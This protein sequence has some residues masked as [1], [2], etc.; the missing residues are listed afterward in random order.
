M[1]VK[2]EAFFIQECLESATPFV[3]EIVVVDTG[4]TDGTRDIAARYADT[5]LDFTWIDDFSAARN[6]GLAAATGDWILVL[7]A[8]ERIAPDDFPR[9]REAAKSAKADGYYLIQR[10]YSD[11]ELELE[12]RP[13]PADDPF[14]RG[15]RGYRENP[16]MR[17]FRRAEGICYE[18][19]IHEIV[20]GTIPEPARATLEVPIHHY[21]DANPER[22]RLQRAARYLELMDRELAE[23]PDGRLYGIAGGSALYAVQ[24]YPKAKHYLR[25]AAEL[26]YQ[27]TR[28]LEGAAEAAYRAG[29]FGEAQDIYRGLYDGG[30]RTPSLCLNMANL[31]VRS[32]ARERAVALLE[33]CLALGGMGPETDQTIRRNIEYLSG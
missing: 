28:S 19:A 9:L 32:G 18:G 26:G 25:R 22:S 10:N 29:E 13:A 11:E 12:W 5:L 2:D 8:D 20:D 14:A 16:I 1:I 33:E 17:L 7:D 6:A 23:R 4:S 30:H 31:S 24:D 3:D 27:V 21:I 15:W